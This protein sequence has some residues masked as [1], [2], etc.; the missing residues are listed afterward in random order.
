MDDQS[1]SLPEGYS[2]GDKGIVIPPA[3]A[4]SLRQAFLGVHAA[5][6]MR[7]MMLQ[8]ITSLIGRSMEDMQGVWK[9]ILG[10]IGERPGE[11]QFDSETGQIY[12][13]AAPRPTVAPQQPSPIQ[14]VG[15]E[16]EERESAPVGFFTD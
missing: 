14:P 16:G 8:A 4:E 9:Q 1:R 12:R 7:D 10:P 2:H 5:N 6:Y 3:L 11:W 15:K 13:M